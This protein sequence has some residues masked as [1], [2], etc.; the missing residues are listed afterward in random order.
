MLTQGQVGPI[1]STVSL[2]TGTQAP[3]RQ[4]NMGDSIVSE[5]HGKYYEAVY[6]RSVFVIANQAAVA[7]TA[8][9][10]TAYTGLVVG[11]PTTSSVNLVMLKASWAFTVT[12]PTAFT[13]VGLMTGTGATITASL[14]P[15]NRFVGGPPG[16]ALANAGQTLPGTPVLE[17]LLNSQGVLAIASQGCNPVQERDLEGSMIL[18]PGGFCAFY[19]MAAN[20]ACFLGSLMWEE[21]PI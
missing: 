11:N 6:R 1:A 12:L 3:Q 2:G 13:V 18:P 20:T 14:T 5:L 9:L 17:S 8:G 15:R 19:S 16:Q 10:A 21:V 4:G 7:L